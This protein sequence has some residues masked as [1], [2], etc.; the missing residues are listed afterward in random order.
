M[1]C[2]TPCPREALRRIR[3]IVL[4]YHGAAGLDADAIAD[5]LQKHLQDNGFECTVAKDRYLLFA[6]RRG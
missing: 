4:E 6:R 3:R 2:S 5:D 1:R